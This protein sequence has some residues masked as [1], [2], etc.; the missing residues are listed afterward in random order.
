MSKILAKFDNNYA[1]EF[2]VSGH[3]VFE[4]TE[5]EKHLEFVK[6]IK[7]PKELYFG[8]NEFIDFYDYEDYFR[9]YKVQPISDEEYE[10]LKKLELLE[11]DMFLFIERDLTDEEL[12]EEN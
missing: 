10:T 6:T 5:W 12:E 8:T 11:S 2:D 3:K 9:S 1:D 4:L 7:F